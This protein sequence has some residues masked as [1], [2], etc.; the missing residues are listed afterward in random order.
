MRY[1]QGFLR[2]WFLIGV[3]VLG[4]NLMACS[5]DD[6]PLPDNIAK[7][8]ATSV[9]VTDDEQSVD[10]NIQFGRAIS[11][12][13]TVEIEVATLNSEYGVE[14]TTEPASSNGKISIPVQAGST[15]TK[16]TVIKKAELFDGDEEVSFTISNV[17]SGLVISSPATV[18]VIFAEIVVEDGVMDINGGGATYTNKV[19][20][21]LSAA[22][23]VAV[24]RKSWDLGFYNGND[25]RVTLNASTNMF[26]RPLTKSSLNDVTAQDTIG[27]GSTMA[28]GYTVNGNFEWTDDASGDL[29]NT[30]IKGISTIDSENAVYIVKP[31]EGDWKKVRIIRDGDDGYKIQYANINS[32]SYVEKS[33]KKDPAYNF[34]YFSFTN[35]NVV[36]VE[37][38][39][40]RWDL[41]WSYYMHKT[42]VSGSFI[43]YGYQDMV[44]TNIHGG[45]KSFEV[46]ATETITYDSF[47]ES[48]LTSLTLDGSNQLVIG[49]NWRATSM[50]GASVKT[51]RFYIIEDLSGN[52]YKLKFNSLVKDGVRGTPQI[53]YA[54]LKKGNLE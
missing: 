25:F 13:G 21:D 10:V 31:E 32:S 44:I 14:Y 11:T 46:L 42:P 18:N 20:V 33:I 24:D 36:S 53:A 8:S 4:I 39:K 48:D 54:L 29:T 41:A 9:G 28:L 38:T 2:M 5:E 23:Q 45:A 50:N 26:A 1:V 47:K 27:F 52:V 6:P 43:A 15:G 7:F 37:P 19:F 40:D 35:G 12:E 30:A 51:D 3:T 34:N 49:S 16:I 22:R 17:P